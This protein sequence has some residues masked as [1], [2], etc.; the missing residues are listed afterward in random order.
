MAEGAA[1]PLLPVELAAV[2]VP[3]A[4][5]HGTAFTA[6]VWGTV[7]GQRTGVQKTL[8]RASGNWPA[9]QQRQVRVVAGR[10]DTHR[11]Q[12]GRRGAASE[13][14]GASV[15]QHAADGGTWETS[16]ELPFEQHPDDVG[17]LPG[18]VG[19]DAGRA[20]PKFKGKRP[21]P[22]DSALNARSKSRA[23]VQSIHATKQYSSKVIEW[24]TQ[25][26]KEWRRCHAMDGVERAVNLSTLKPE[27]YEAWLV[28]SASPVSF[29]Q[30]RLRFCSIGIT[31]STTRF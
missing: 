31:I 26:A 9:V 24:A 3:A 18:P 20:L 27:W 11:P 8:Y 12:T 4:A 1:A 21:G 14:Y 2:T 25:H 17:W 28:S 5:A 15:K 19:G 16:E 13:S 23:I 22:T 10:R 30:S 29:R 6:N 7:K